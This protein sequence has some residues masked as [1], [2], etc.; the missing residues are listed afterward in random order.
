MFRQVPRGPR[1]HARTTRSQVNYIRIVWRP[2]ATYYTKPLESYGA[3]LLRTT[4]MTRETGH[5]ALAL[6]G[7]EVVRHAFPRRTVG[8]VLRKPAVHGCVGAWVRGHGG[9]HGCVSLPK[10]QRRAVSSRSTQCCVCVHAYASGG[11]QDKGHRERTRGRERA[12]ARARGREREA[13][14]GWCCMQ[15]TIHSRRGTLLALQH[16]LQVHRRGD[17]SA[18]RASMECRYRRGGSTTELTVRDLL[19][20][21]TLT[22]TLR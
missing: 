10:P 2:A 18:T 21:L 9:G 3:L 22:L 13:C 7:G 14:C 8:L 17:S 19:L 15:D 5:C 20:T 6:E 1:G 11:A 16:A 12:R 4:P